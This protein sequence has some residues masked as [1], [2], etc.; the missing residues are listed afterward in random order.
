MMEAACL[1]DG[2]SLSPG[3]RRMQWAVMAPEG[4]TMS[5]GS[6]MFNVMLILYSP[7]IILVLFVFIMSL[8]HLSGLAQSL[9]LFCAALD[10]ADP[11]LGA[12]TCIVSDA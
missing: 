1:S 3:R 7:D 11:S 12:R 10:C 4:G 2:M 9:I 5:V 8:L 6:A